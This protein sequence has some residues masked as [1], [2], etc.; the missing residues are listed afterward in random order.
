MPSKPITFAKACKLVQKSLACIFDGGV[1]SYPIINE[2]FNGEDCI[3]ISYNDDDGLRE[4]S[5]GKKHEYF[6]NDGV[7]EI[8]SETEEYTVQFLAIVKVK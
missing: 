6:L 2:D 7:L 8:K 5:F 4:H 3:A 1:L